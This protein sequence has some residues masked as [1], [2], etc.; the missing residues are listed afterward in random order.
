[1]STFCVPGT[2]PGMEAGGHTEG[3]ALLSRGSPHCGE[4][5]RHGQDVV[6]PL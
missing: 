5:E 2:G 3:Q 6:E 1:M 4:T